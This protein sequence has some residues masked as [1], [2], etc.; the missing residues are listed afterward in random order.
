MAITNQTVLKKMSSEIQE[1]ML[2]HGDQQ[3]VREHV[4]SVKL[5]ADL[6]LEEESS[7]TQSPSS[8]QEPTVEEIRKMMGADKQPSQLQRTP[9]S[10]QETKSDHEE[11]NGSSIF[12]F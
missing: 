5:L 7:T 8:V 2:Q 10:K 12:D 4:R 6:L 1:A 11:A 3:K 9:Q